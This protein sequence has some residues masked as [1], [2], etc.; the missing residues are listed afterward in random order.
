[1]HACNRLNRCLG[2]HRRLHV[3]FTPGRSAAGNAVRAFA[4][5]G[6]EKIKVE[7]P[8]VDLD[9]DEMTRCVGILGGGASCIF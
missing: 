5:G 4:S 8:V 7:N 3:I 6:F 2:G 1:L 9:G